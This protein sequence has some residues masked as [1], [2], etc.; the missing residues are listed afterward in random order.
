MEGGSSIV[1]VVERGCKACH[2]CRS[3]S[4]KFLVVV[5][6]ATP[7]IGCSSCVTRLNAWPTDSLAALL[8]HSLAPYT[9]THAIHQVCQTDR[10]V[11]CVV[12]HSHRLLLLCP[13]QNNTQRRALPASPQTVSSPS[14]AHL[15]AQTNQ[16]NL[17]SIEPQVQLNPNPSKNNISGWCP[18][19]LTAWKPSHFPTTQHPPHPSYRS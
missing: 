9:S 18:D 11:D 10:Q 4:F 1:L 15:L 6:V 8:V 17:S 7:R 16:L 3:Q 14:I 12:W 5:V 2:L 13:H 19:S